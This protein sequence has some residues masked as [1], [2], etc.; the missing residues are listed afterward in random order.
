MYLEGKEPQFRAP[1]RRSNPY[2][3]MIL[4]VLIAVVIA[5]LRSY[6]KGDIQPL[7]M[8]TATPTRTSNSYIVEANTHFLAGNLDKAIE[9]YKLASTLDPLDT[10]ILVKLAQVQTYSS[11][12][13]TTD[14]ER[15]ARLSDALISIDKAKEIAPQDSTVLAVRAFV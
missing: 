13:L 4:L 3:V 9:A 8:P 5:V 14:A 1:K 12:S 15:K 7:F 2:W 11:N 10:S 6:A